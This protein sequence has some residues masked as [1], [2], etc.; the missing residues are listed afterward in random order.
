MIKPNQEEIKTILKG[1][2]STTNDYCR[3]L[4]EFKKMG[5]ELP[6]ISLGKK[7][8]LASLDISGK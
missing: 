2:F 5:I 8:S 6:V 1:N 4:K 3:A 7:G